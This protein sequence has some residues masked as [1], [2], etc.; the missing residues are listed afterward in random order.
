MY[1]HFLSLLF[2]SSM[3]LSQAYADYDH[4]HADID[5][6]LKTH[7]SLKKNGST[8]FAYAK[9]KRKPVEFIRYLKNASKVTEKQFNSWT[10]EEQI[11]FLINV[12]NG[13]TI[14]LVMDNYPTSSIKKI[15]G[16]SPSPWKV[17]FIRLLGKSMNLDNIET[18]WLRKKYNDPRIHFATNSSTVSSP[19]LRNEAYVASRLN[20]QLDDQV[21]TFVRNSSHNKINQADKKLELSK[22]FSWYKEDFTNADMSVQKFVS[23]YISDEKTIQAALQKNEYDVDYLDYNWDLN[24]TK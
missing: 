1:T 7:V 16:L 23:Q 18:D 4:T 14:Q 24:N 11:A 15:K 13:F 21:K 6:V 22:L 19:H 9:L 17:N 12:Y 10:R 2:A 3:V 20:E 8:T 5:K